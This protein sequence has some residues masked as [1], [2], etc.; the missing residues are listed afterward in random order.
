MLRATEPAVVAGGNTTWMRSPEGS[1]AERS[2]DS[3]S[4][5]W[6]VELATSFA[7]LRHQSKL[8]NGIDSR[9]QP[10]RG[11]R[12]ATP[13]SFT[14]SSVTSDRVRSGRSGRRVS[15][16][17]DAVPAGTRS[18]SCGLELIHGPE[19]EVP[20]HQHLDPVSLGLPDR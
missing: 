16:S 12:Y 4:M 15:S 17:A 11:S 20:R 19:I 1:D 9:R 2:G 14:Q 6:R 8:A 13:G 5:R 10:S 3:S 18:A 7:R